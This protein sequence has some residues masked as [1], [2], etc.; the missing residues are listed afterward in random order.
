MKMS[1][2]SANCGNYGVGA[3]RWQRSNKVQCRWQA[4]FYHF[5]KANGAQKTVRQ[6]VRLAIKFVSFEELMPFDE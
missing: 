3:K 2:L 4:P 6:A 1:K 5:E